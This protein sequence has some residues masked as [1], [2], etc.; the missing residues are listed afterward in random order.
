LARTASKSLAPN[1]RMLRK[2][3]GGATTRFHARL[4]ASGLASR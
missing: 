3:P 2:R 1:P 4:F